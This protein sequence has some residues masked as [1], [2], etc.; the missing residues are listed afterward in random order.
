[1]NYFIF[2]IVGF[3]ICYISDKLMMPTATW[4]SVV[5][6]FVISCLS[7]LSISLF[8]LIG[9]TDELGKLMDIKM[10]K[11]PYKWL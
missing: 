5:V 3:L 11:K 4:R 7:W 2:Y 10:T 1:M 8:L 9:L 6:R